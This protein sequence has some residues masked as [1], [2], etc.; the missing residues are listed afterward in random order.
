M[1]VVLA[2]VFSALLLP[3]PF[4]GRAATA[5]GDLVHAPLF[6]SLAIAWLLVWQRLDP[7]N[8]VFDGP[9]IHQGRRLVSRGI[10]IWISLSL[11]GLGM[12][13][14]QRGTGRSASVHDAI[15]N[16]L[17]VA[18]AIA[19]YSAV[20][21][22]SRHRNRAAWSFA[23]VAV[24]ILALAWWRPVVLLADVIAMPKQFPLLAS[25]ESPAELTRWYM[26]K[27]TGKRVRTDATD[28]RYALEVDYEAVD[29]PA[30]TLIEMVSDWSDYSAL[31]L[32]AILLDETADGSQSTASV[33]L[34]IQI[35]IQSDGT[36]LAYKESVML[37]P[38]Q[39][40]HIRLALADFTIRLASTDL[41]D[42]IDVRQVMFLDIG[43]LNPGSATRFRFDRLTLVR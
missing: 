22:A 37:L 39:P 3:V 29:F 38:G 25:F 4:A 43:P 28:G 6:G 40:R 31:E 19:G 42:E 7:L 15:A 36:R 11:F 12:E 41:A 27:C 5:L 35:I 24:M 20:W 17:G 34:L 14:L 2:T 30:I 33:P 16:S 8:R 9:R 1:L 32:D 26:R 18:A 13:F 23:S 21:F 10:I